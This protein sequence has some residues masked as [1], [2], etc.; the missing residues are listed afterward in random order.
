[1]RL[2][3]I[4]L[5]WNFYRGVS[6]SGETKESFLDDTDELWSE[7]KYMHIAEATK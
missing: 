6:S 4:Q 3:S 1:M 5:N 7:L 2:K